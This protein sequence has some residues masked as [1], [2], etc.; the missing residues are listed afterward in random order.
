[1]EESINVLGSKLE[2]C[3]IDPMTGWFRDGCCN[4][5]KR[6]YGRHVVCAVMTDVFLAFSKVSKTMEVK[7]LTFLVNNN[8]LSIGF[9]GTYGHLIRKFSS[10]NFISYHFLHDQ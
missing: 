7:T 6:D 1:M 10:I 2:S 5:D 8:E 4:T 3:S 9:Y